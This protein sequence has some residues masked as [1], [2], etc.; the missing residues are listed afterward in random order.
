MQ[1]AAGRHPVIERI[2]GEEAGRF[3]PNDLFL[4]NGGDRIALITGPNMGGKRH[5]SSAKPR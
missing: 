2:A 4:N 1:I 3:I 5:L